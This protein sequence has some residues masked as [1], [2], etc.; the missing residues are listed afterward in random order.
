[1]TFKIINC[2]GNRL[3]VD[4]FIQKKFSEEEY[5]NAAKNFADQAGYYG[6]YIQPDKYLYAFCEFHDDLLEL[7]KKI[8]AYKRLF[9]NKSTFLLEEKFIRLSKRF[10]HNCGVKVIYEFPQYV[11]KKKK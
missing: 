4:N 1:M 6:G 5:I 10:E 11:S 2:I 9:G 8:M 7:M 3:H